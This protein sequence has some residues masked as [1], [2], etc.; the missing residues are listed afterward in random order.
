MARAQHALVRV[1]RR[2]AACCAC[3]ARRRRARCG[4]SAATRSPAYAADAEVRPAALPPAAVHLLARRR[5]DA[6]GR[7]HPAA[8]GDG[9]PRRASARA[10]S[11]TSTCSGRRS[12]CQPGHHVQGAQP[13]G[14]S[15]ERQRRLVRLLDRARP[16]RARRRSTPPR[17]TTRSRSTC[18]PA[19]SS[20]SAPSC[21]TPTRKPADPITLYV[22]A[23]ADGDVHALRRRRTDLRLREGRL[24]AH[25][26]ALERRHPDAHHRQARGILHG[27]ADSR[28]PSRSFLCRGT[29]AVGFSFTPTAD[30]T[31]TY[32]GAPST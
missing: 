7:Y 4:S 27:H 19:R 26:A 11:A 21:S 6:R 5:R 9:F 18:A 10:T 32:D 24:R 30:K 31:V 16:R 28:V 14:L 29:K 12:S 8:A 2:S 1:R 15:A 23:G 3:T 13:L 20:P 22:Y 25:P 17:R